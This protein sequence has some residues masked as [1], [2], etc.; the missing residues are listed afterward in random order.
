LCF[1]YCLKKIGVKIIAAASNLYEAS[2]SGWAVLSLMKITADEADISAII[3]RKTLTTI[4]GFSL[5]FIFI[6]R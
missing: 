3:R 2:I 1:L 5:L 4:R 6:L